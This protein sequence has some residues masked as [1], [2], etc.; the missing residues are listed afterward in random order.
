MRP[1]VVLL[2]A[3][4]STPSFAALADGVSSAV[5]ALRI[6]VVTLYGLLIAAGVAVFVARI[7]AGRFT[8]HIHGVMN[9]QEQR[10]HDARM[11]SYERSQGH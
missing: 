10:I 3:F 2:L 5:D 8:G 7:L 6:A 11:R 4:A 1:L 9:E